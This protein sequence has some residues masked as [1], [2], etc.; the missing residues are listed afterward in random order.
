[1]FEAPVDVVEYLGS[2][3]LVYLTIAGKTM[4]ARLD[5]RSSAHVGGSLTLRVNSA[6][7]H[8]FDTETGVAIF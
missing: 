8:L 7:L 3:L 6:H 5:P 1:M 4:T 2:E